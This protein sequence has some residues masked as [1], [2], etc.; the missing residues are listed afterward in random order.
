VSASFKLVAIDGVVERVGG[1][2]L[3]MHGR[4]TARCQ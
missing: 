3:E 2:V 4:S 1:E